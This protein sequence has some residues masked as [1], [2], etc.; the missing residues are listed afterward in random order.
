MISCTGHLKKSDFESLHSIID[1]YEINCKFEELRRLGY[2]DEYIN[3]ELGHLVNWRIQIMVEKQLDF[4]KW[5]LKKDKYDDLTVESARDVLDE[6]VKLGYGDFELL[7]GYDSNLVYT[8]FT[9]K[10]FVIEKDEKIL[11]KE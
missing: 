2:S 8:G 4:S 6:L 9:D 7:I 5:S 3:K 10:V 1:G 11:V